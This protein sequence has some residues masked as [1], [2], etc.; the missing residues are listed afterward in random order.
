[1]WS[2]SFMLYTFLPQFDVIIA[3]TPCSS[4]HSYAATALHF[5]SFSMPVAPETVTEI[6]QASP[7]W[8]ARECGRIQL[9]TTWEGSTCA[10]AAMAAIISVLTLLV[11]L[12]KSSN[13][14]LSVTVIVIHLVYLHQNPLSHAQLS[15]EEPPGADHVWEGHCSGAIVEGG[16]KKL[17]VQGLHLI[18]PGVVAKVPETHGRQLAPV[19]IPRAVEYVPAVQLVHMAQD[20]APEAVEKVPAPQQAHVVDAGAPVPVK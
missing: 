13:V 8:Q 1:M 2:H 18:A 15:L 10:A 16:Q 7:L 9:I 4:L 11:L 6:L 3:L 19:T 20:T 17:A 5:C 12:L 14:Q